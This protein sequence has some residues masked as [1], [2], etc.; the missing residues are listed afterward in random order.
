MRREEFVYQL[1]RLYKGSRCET[2]LTPERIGALWEAYGH[3]SAELWKNAVSRLLMD[4]IRPTRSRIE[5]SLSACEHDSQARAARARGNQHATEVRETWERARHEYGKFRLKLLLLT[6]GG[7]VTPAEIAEILRCGMAE[8]P[9]IE[10]QEVDYW[11]THKP[12]EKRDPPEGS[13]A[14]HA[15]HALRRQV[16]EQHEAQHRTP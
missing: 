10:Q 13:A 11:D 16:D 1:E 6:L 8:H 7:Q 5:E 12:W 9:E 14:W 2:D 4:P 3:E 15:F